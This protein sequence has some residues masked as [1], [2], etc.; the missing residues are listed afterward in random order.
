[1]SKWNKKELDNML[2]DVV[3]ELELSESALAEHG[4][5]GTAPSELVRLVLEEKDLRIRALEANFVDASKS[6]LRLQS[7]VRSLLLEK[8]STCGWLFDSDFLRKT[9]RKANKHDPLISMEQVEYVLRALS[10]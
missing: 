5:A 10:E 9:T 8:P 3:N 4:P 2:E 7:V 1:M 6:C